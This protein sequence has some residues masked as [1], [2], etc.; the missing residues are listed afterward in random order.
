[1][2]CEILLTFGSKYS[3]QKEK[4]YTVNLPPWCSVASNKTSRNVK[5]SD[6]PMSHSKQEWRQSGLLPR[7]G[8]WKPLMHI[9]AC[10]PLSAR[11]WQGPL[12][13]WRHKMKGTWTVEWPSEEGLPQQP[14]Y[15]SRTVMWTRNKCVLCWVITLVYPDQKNSHCQEFPE[16]CP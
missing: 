2:C 13:W 3:C 7:P 15:P 12:G 5:A 14:T 8:P 11:W 9:P 1:M 4:T 16:L 6:F 10:F